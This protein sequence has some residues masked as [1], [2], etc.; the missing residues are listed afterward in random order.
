MSKIPLKIE[1][2]IYHEDDDEILDD[3][4]IGEPFIKYP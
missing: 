3:L 4:S 1:P 2:E